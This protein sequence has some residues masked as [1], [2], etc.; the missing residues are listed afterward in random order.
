MRYREAK[1]ISVDTRRA[2]LERQNYKSISGRHLTE[3]SASF[4]HYVERSSSG[5]GFEWNIVALTFEE[6]R[7]IHD[8]KDILYDPYRSKLVLYTYERFMEKI[9]EHLKEN[10]EGWSEDLCKFHKGWEIEDYG[11]TRRTHL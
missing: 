9:I 7:A 6:H 2:V 4:H 5:V 8:K 11:I 10:Y 1:Q 3:E